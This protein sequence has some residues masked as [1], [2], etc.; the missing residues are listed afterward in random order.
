MRDDSSGAKAGSDTGKTAPNG[1]KRAGWFGLRFGLDHANRELRVCMTRAVAGVSVAGFCGLLI[2][3]VAVSRNTSNSGPQSAR[4]ASIIDPTA[5]ENVPRVAPPAQ[6]PAP[7][8]RARPAQ[9][10]TSAK[11][12]V[13]ANVPVKAPAVAPAPARTKAS[14]TTSTT[15]DAVNKPRVAPALAPAM[16][17]T[18][19][20]TKAVDGRTVGHNYLV[21]GSYP[22]QAEARRVTQ[23]LKTGGVACTIER[24]LPG[25]TRKGWYSVVGV[26]GHATTKTPAYQ[27]EVK[28]VEDLGLEPRAYRWRKTG[29]A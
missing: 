22:T 17:M 25:W 9:L 12:L 3:V 15:P 6:K 4:A 28:S 13:A 21:F 26:N 29:G 27:A 1:A 11:P 16:T 7:P 5:E 8:A 18:A 14:P 23:K 20:T 19:T 2:G 24:S 10:H